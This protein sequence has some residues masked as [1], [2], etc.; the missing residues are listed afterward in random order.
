MDTDIV[1][2]FEQE[3]GLVVDL[4]A[5]DR[6]NETLARIL[7]R[8]DSIEEVQ[9]QQGLKQDN[10]F[11]APL[12]STDIVGN[13]D[14]FAAPR[15]GAYARPLDSSMDGMDDDDRHTNRCTHLCRL[16]DDW[17]LLCCG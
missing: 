16:I 8:L 2:K 17:W 11:T 13:D 5:M 6:V 4:R 7:L 10:L 3:E 15:R 12:L 9:R 14:L 1:K